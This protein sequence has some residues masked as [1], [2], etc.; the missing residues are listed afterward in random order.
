MF[1]LRQ[2]LETELRSNILPFWLRYAIDQEYGGFRG[3]IANDLTIDPL[4]P[5]GLI[6]N[7][8]LLWTFSR[9]F[10]VYGEEVYLRTARRAY[11]YLT[12][13]FWDTEFNGVFWLLDYLGRPLESK[14]RI[15]GQTFTVYALAEYHRATQDP[16]SLRKARRLY[17][18]IESASH[19]ARHGG[20]FETLERDWTLARDQRLSEVDMD[21]KKSMNTHL[22]LLEAYADL[23]RS[24][25][26]SALR[27]RL[28]EL[29]RAFLDHIIDPETHHYRMFFDEEWHPRS[30]HV[31]FGHDIE[32]SWL[33]C[34]A[35][36][37]LGDQPLLAKVRQ[38]AVKMA[39]AVLDE[40]VDPD[41]GLLYE[42]D[43]RGIIN[44]DK[45]W[46]P[47]AE[48]VVGFLNAYQLSGWDHFRVAACKS[49]DFIEKYLVDRRHGEWF[50]KVSRAGIPSQD[51]FKVD[52][53]KCPYHNS[54][55]CL[56]VM[57]R[58]D[59]MEHAG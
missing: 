10:R 31:S 32:G 18:A 29:I 19:D 56:E 49:W 44:T 3:Q 43:S 42:A 35:A 41:G 53:W 54:R 26:D 47:Q 11:E 1:N 45:E 39:Q 50:W 59:S 16:E 5:K 6:L 12:Q 55:A 20:Y 36:E 30:D 38:E 46:W 37:I 4:A 51:K 24:W 34:E 52:Q 21:E 2:R 13:F 57:A 25:E 14:K 15:Y 48:A 8:R 58:L 27:G 28:Q 7:A 23:L 9:A 40:A 33:L 17:E 22:H